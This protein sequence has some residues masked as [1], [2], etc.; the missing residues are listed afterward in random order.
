VAWT[1]DTI[2][3]QNAT[4]PLVTGISPDW[5]R[6]TYGPVSVHYNAAASNT[7]T[8]PFDYTFAMYFDG[9]TGGVESIGLGY[10]ADGQTNWQLCGSA[11]V[12]DHGIPG[13]GDWDSDYATAGVVIHGTDGIWRMWYSGSGPSGG[14]QQGIG[15]ATSTDGISWAKDPGNPI[16][17]IFQGV[18]WR[19][20][21]CYTPSVLYS[22]SGFDG[23]GD[24][25][26]YKMWFTG[27]ALFTGNRTIDMRQ[28][29]LW[30]K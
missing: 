25:S 15:Y 5:N 2:I 23:H 27:Q 17:S 4:A 6:G 20:A 10:S 13:G 29:L 3:T 28:G 1:N 26:A 30:P 21:R 19:N 22:S 14:A 24:A 9:T 8:N 7:G 12:L 11:P 16:F 18:A